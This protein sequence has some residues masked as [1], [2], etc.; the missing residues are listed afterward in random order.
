[1]LE[2]ITCRDQACRD[3]KVYLVEIIR[4]ILCMLRHDHRNRITIHRFFTTKTS[5]TRLINTIIQYSPQV[6]PGD[7]PQVQNVVVNES[8]TR[9]K[10]AEIEIPPDVFSVPV[11]ILYKN[12]GANQE[13]GD[14]YRWEHVPGEK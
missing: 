2:F 14:V 4:I 8:G 10:V 13:V 6:I 9:F 12:V 11:T 1:L 3:Q 7:Q 5:I